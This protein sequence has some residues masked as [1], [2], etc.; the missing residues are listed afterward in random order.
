[1]RL[2]EAKYCRFGLGALL[3]LAVVTLVSSGPD[4]RFEAARAT[5]P[6]ANMRAHVRAP[7]DLANP[8]ASA[9]QSFEALTPE[10]A[11]EANAK[12]PISRA[13]NPPARPLLLTN[14]GAPDRTL[15]LSCLTSAVYYE[16][17]NQGV[18]GEAAVAQVVLNRLRS[19][20][21]PKTICGVVFEGSELKTGCQFTFTCD[22]SLARRPEPTLWRGAREVAERALN[23]YVQKSV[24]LATHYHTI[25]VVPYWQSS[26]IKVGQ[27]GAHIFYRM[28]GGP[29][30]AGGFT[31]AYAGAEV[32]PAVLKRID[33]DS[34]PGSGAHIDLVAAPK[35]TAA[36]AALAPQVIAKPAQPVEVAGRAEVV[37]AA[38]PTDFD[39]PKPAGFFGHQ[40][41]VQRLPIA[42]P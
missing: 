25:W 36:A 26:V 8:I 1:M 28:D 14:A 10:E 18:A 13:P 3:T 31:S 42:S 24:G 2:Y 15:A 33:P 29:G 40:G 41:S 27:I 11:V 32:L 30:S 12:V 20:I 6:A 5:A 22:G 17:A 38:I 7:V 39:P 34:G 37:M 16:A 19:P 23:G 9:P 21:F 4:L 35:L